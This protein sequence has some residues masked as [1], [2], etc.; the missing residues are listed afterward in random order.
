[1]SYFHAQAA[2]YSEFRPDYPEE[3]WR[4]AASLVAE[5]R[6]AWDCATGNGQAAVG[7][8]RHFERVIAT[9]ISEPQLAYARPVA[10]VEYRKAPAEQSGLA[11]HSADLANVSQALHWLDRPRFFAEAKRVLKPG[12]VLMITMYGDAHIAGAEDLDA[13][14]QWFNKDFMRDYWPVNRKLVEDLYGNI[15][16]PFEPLPAPK[17]RLERRWTLAQLAGYMRSWSATSQYVKKHGGDPVGELEQKMRGLWGESQSKTVW[18]PFR[19]MAGK[20]PEA[21]S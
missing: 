17:F 7:L 15:Q 4:W 14:L 9:D 16:L 10:N 13:L 20:L 11:E 1:M 6:L 18:W 21:R 12:G 19:V 8:A 2:Q 5:H 3:L